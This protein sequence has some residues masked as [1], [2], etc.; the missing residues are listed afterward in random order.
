[1]K[2]LISFLE[3]SPTA[4]HAVSNIQ[5][6][7]KKNGFTHLNG[8]EDW[9]L[10]PGHKYY[11]TRDGSSLIAFIVPKKEIKTAKV[12]ASH[13]DSPALK[14]KPNAAFVKEGMLML[15]VDIYGGPLLNAWL[16][17]DLGIAGRVFSQEKNKDLVQTLI[18]ITDSPV[19]IPQL[20]IHLDRE[21]N[22]QGLVL[23]KQNHLAALA[24][25]NCKDDKEASQFLN[26]LLGV[27]NILSSDLFL[28]P[29]EA[30]AFIG[31]KQEMLAAYRIDSLCSVHSILTA[32]LET[33]SPAIDTLKICAFWD[34]EEIGSETPQGASS[35]FFSETVERLVYALKGSRADYL[36]IISS[37][38]CLS[39]DLA[40]GIHPNYPDKH[41]PQHKVRLGQGIILKH[42]SQQRY[43][44]TAATAGY[45][46][47][48]CLGNKIP[49]QELV[50]RGDIASGSTIGPIHAHLTGMPTVDIGIPQLSMHSTRELI[51]C[52]DQAAMT[53]FLTCFF[54]KK[55]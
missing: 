26:K 54:Q 12:A 52:S 11:T 15:G 21:V 6:E 28:Y 42:S 33:D 48:L 18:N 2:S 13:T 8:N 32:F 38:L 45:V 9:N 31:P 44:S 3:K 41:E 7:L 1:M 46:K 14:L 49:F 23:H 37:S 24:K 22:N 36:R 50:G 39:V 30:P 29:L 35:P 27:K 47:S 55:N 19:T 34:N 51:A 20:A 16:N 4:W 5:Q 40:H 25:L 17:R 10:K 53:Q 43:A